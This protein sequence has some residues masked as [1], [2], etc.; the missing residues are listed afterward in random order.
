MGAAQ[1]KDACDEFV[2]EIHAKS[3]LRQRGVEEGHPWYSQT[4]VDEN[5]CRVFPKLPPPGQHPRLFL[6]AEEL[7]HAL[8][9]FECSQNGISGVLS[10]VTVACTNTFRAYRKRILELPASERLQPSRETVESFFTEDASRGETWLIAY[11][12]GFRNND[13]V[14]MDGVVE[15]VVF[16]ARIIIASQK[17]AHDEDLRT[18]PFHIWH[19]KAFNLP[20][21]FLLG[22]SGYAACYDILYNSFAPADAATVRQAIAL[23]AAGRRSW[24]MG[25]P[26]RRIQ[27]N[28]SGYH[29]DLLVMWAAIEG[30]EGFDREAYNSFADMMHNFFEFG[31]YESG[32][33]VEDS[34]ALNLCLREG[35]YAM[36]ALARR[37]YNFFRH[38]RYKKMITQWMP[39]GLEPQRDGVFYGG[40]SGSDII[41]PTSAIIAKFMFPQDPVI[42]FVYRHFLTDYIKLNKYQSRLASALFALPA[43]EEK[44]DASRI[45]DASNLN[46]ERTFHCKDRGKAVLRSEWSEN[47]MWFTL[48]ARGDAFLVGHDTASRGS[49]V[50]SVDGRNWSLSREWNQ[51][52]ESTDFSLMRIDGMGQREKAPSCKLICC[53]EGVACSTFTAA[54]LTYPYNWEWTTW[55]KTER[56][57]ASQGWEWEPHS[58]RDFGMTAWWLPEKLYNEPDVGFEGLNICRRRINTVQKVTRSALM[59]R[60]A[61]RP[62]LLITDDALKDGE[63]REYAWLMATLPDIELDSFDGRDAILRESAS[64]GARRLLIRVLQGTGGSVVECKHERYSKLDTKRKDK[65]G[66]H[67]E[68][69]GHRLVLTT[70]GREATFRLLIF[71]FGDSL[72]SLPATS[73]LDE[74]RLQ[75]DMAAENAATDGMQHEASSHIIQYSRGPEHGE[76][77]MSVVQ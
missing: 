19:T 22:T 24:G 30:E 59:V 3:S 68:L 50:L 77:R 15:T 42:D 8:A 4:P 51:W 75:V 9:R 55:K 29:G 45:H 33:T 73:W 58:P 43:T 38:P 32:H 12:Q 74:N 10:K 70:R 23:G 53:E 61:P 11:V 28:W 64:E 71:G 41:Y 49:F 36:L 6:T 54:D 67:P 40:S 31:V 14:L 69:V 72:S 65:D 76:T 52:K 66:Q 56:E 1:C 7:P 27:S 5:G 2:K 46:L 20:I 57:M 26:A 62:Y 48:D 60:Q 13:H 25:F 63:E 18:K 17:L 47:A 16:Y 34:Y 21:S 35:S 37:G 44:L 39:F